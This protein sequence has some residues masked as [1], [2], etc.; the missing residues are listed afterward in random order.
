MNK[1]PYICLEGLDG[2][3]KTTA[4]HHIMS[5]LEEEGYKVCGVC[6]TQSACYCE[7]KMECHCHTIEKLFNQY[8]FLHKHRFLR[9]FLYAFRSNHAASKI[10]WTADLLLGDRSIITSYVCRWTRFRFL[11]CLLINIVNL[12]EYKIPVPDYVFYLEVSTKTLCK[13]LSYRN[14]LDIDETDKRSKAMRYAYNVIQ[15]Q[16]GEIKRISTVQWYTIDGNQPED[17]VSHEIFRQIMELLP[18]KFMK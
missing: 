17:T 11:N 5:L 13:R 6:P 12:L 3:G 15:I 14:N 7:N 18:K 1:I 4:Y 9:M 2:A 10:D 8:P 16:T